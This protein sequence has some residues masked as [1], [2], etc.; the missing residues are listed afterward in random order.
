MSSFR[1]KRRAQAGERDKQSGKKA[2][3]QTD[4]EGE[5]GTMLQSGV[6]QGF[7]SWTREGK[8][9]AAAGSAEWGNFLKRLVCGDLSICDFLES[10]T[11]TSVQ[12]AFSDLPCV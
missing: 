9:T 12:R 6:E 3:R 8:K 4:G 1:K 2:D 11:F 5:N 7:H 10:Q